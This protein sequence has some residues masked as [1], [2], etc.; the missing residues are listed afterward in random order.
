MNRWLNTM[1]GA[2]SLLTLSLAL[3]S[4]DADAQAPPSGGH[5]HA[6]PSPPPATTPSAP[7]RVTM[8][9][10][11]QHGGVPRGWTFTLPAGDAAR[12]RGL[13]RELECY[14][15]HEIRGAGFPPSGG[16]AKNVG[17][18]LTAMGAHHPAEY[19]AES[20]IAPNHVIVEGPG[21]VGPDGLSIMPSFS[22]SLSVVQW[23][24]LVAYLKSLSDGGDRHA[25]HEITR[26][27]IAGDYRIRVMY[28]GGA[29][30]PEHHHGGGG[31]GHLMVFVLDRETGE[32]VPYLPV[33]A[34]LHAAG[35]PVRT[36]KLSPMTGAPGFHYGADV[37]LPERTERIRLSIGAVTMRV[38]D[39]TKGRFAK[40]VSSTFGWK[41]P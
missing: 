1:L 36:L 31:A 26:E 22:D 20:I 27:Q 8:E 18:E 17:P 24:D 29:G 13:F 25:G 4:G 3:T 11:H 41:A 40:P 7:R 21:F 6:A 30:G 32:A 9:Q 2:G 34:T 35:A 33:T 28:T 19:F 37:V 12:G 15:C 10:L 16:D 23:I 38:M 39:S 14:K 5:Q